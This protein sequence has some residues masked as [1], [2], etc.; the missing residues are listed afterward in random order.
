MARSVPRRTAAPEQALLDAWFT[1]HGWQAFDFQRDVW[2]AMAQGRSGLLHATT[3]SGKT[4]AVWFGALLHARAVQ[5]LRAPPPTAGR[6]KPAPPRGATVS[7][8]A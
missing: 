5:P 1:A 7:I 4:Y 2:T 8:S 6:G 3:G